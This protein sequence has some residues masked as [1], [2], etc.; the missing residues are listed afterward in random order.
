MA[1]RG[2][3]AMH[4]AVLASILDVFNLE[5]LFS[6]PFILAITAFQLWMGI[7]A[8]RRREYL[9]AVF[10]LFFWGLSAVMYYFTVYRSAGPAGGGLAGFELPG[11]A[12]RRRIKELQGRIFHLD[13]ARDH[14]DLADIYFA[15]GKL[16]QAEASYRESLKRDG[17][18]IDAIAHLGQCQL[19]LNRPA[20][21]RP[22][23]EQALAQNPHHDY[24]HT[25]MA[26]AETQMALGE[27]TAAM[28][29]WERVLERN[30][31]ARA[32]VQFA[33]LLASS[34]DRDRAR[35]ELQEAVAEDA[36]VPTFQRNRDKV[37]IRRAKKLLASL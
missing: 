19:R 23:L 24:G 26:L 15:Q 14:L 21:A 20:E 35:R 6:H 3:L 5:Y 10:I 12:S 17:T 25:L 8:L 37:W 16:A 34:G 30:N 29:S 2:P 11:A 4:S 36:H 28:A 31:Y 13:H 33:E 27:S 9:W 18:D 32:R 7:D 1:G 22:L